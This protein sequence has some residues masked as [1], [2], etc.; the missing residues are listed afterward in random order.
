MMVSKSRRTRHSEDMS[1]SLPV[2]ANNH[3]GGSRTSALDDFAEAAMRSNTDGMM[4]DKRTATLAEAQE[5]C[6]PH[7]TPA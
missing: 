5:L 7:T 4:H 1:Q 2:L 3:D 6:L